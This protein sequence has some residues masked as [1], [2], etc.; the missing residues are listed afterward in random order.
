MM[1]DRPSEDD[2]IREEVREDRCGGKR[3][4][5]MDARLKAYYYAK[6]RL[7]TLGQRRG[8]EYKETLLYEH[9]SAFGTCSPSKRSAAT[10]RETRGEPGIVSHSRQAAGCDGTE[11]NSGLVAFLDLPDDG[12]RCWLDENDDWWF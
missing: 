11:D 3:I 9:P 5:D 6:K 2:Q 10:P 8:P 1:W 4:E 7:A 12:P